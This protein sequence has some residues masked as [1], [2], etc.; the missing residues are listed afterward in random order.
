MTKKKSIKKITQQFRWKPSPA[1]DWILKTDRTKFTENHAYA[2]L[3]VLLE[4]YSYLQQAYGQ[5]Y[6]TIKHDDFWNDERAKELRFRTDYI[7][8]KIKAKYYGMVET[9]DRMDYHD[10]LEARESKKSES[11]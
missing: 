9:I 5:M 8:E 1:I 2:P 3:S 4:E 11:K 7:E 10:M 6:T